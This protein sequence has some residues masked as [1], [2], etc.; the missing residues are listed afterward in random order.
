MYRSRTQIFV[1]TS[2]WL[3]IYRLLSRTNMTLPLILR[4]HLRGLVTVSFKNL[5]FAKESNRSFPNARVLLKKQDSINIL[6]L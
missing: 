3:L 1:A 4:H 2:S 5:Q 6:P